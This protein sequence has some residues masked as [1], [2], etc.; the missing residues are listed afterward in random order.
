MT[1]APVHPRSRGEHI[2]G[3][4]RPSASAGSSPLARG[5]LPAGSAHPRRHRFIP[6]R[7]GNTSSAST[8]ATRRPV[9]PRSRGEH[10]YPS[11]VR[12]TFA[13]SSPLARGTRAARRLGMTR[14]RFIPARAGNTH[15]ARS[16]SQTSPVHPR[17]RGEHVAGEERRGLQI[18]F[19]PA[20]A[21][22]TCTATASVPGIAVHPRSRGEHPPIGSTARDVAG[23]SP[24]ARGTRGRTGCD[25]DDG[26]FIPARAGEHSASRH[27][28]P[29]PA[30]SSPLARGTPKLERAVQDELRFIPARAGNTKDGWVLCA[31]RPVH[32]RSRGEHTMPWKS[33]ARAA[34]S[35]PLARGTRRSAG[36][37]RTR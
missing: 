25:A 20:R 36:T 7:A 35:S 27:K 17:S 12:G 29:H 21:G 23:S 22:N 11:G 3:H 6:A 13:G 32:P 37:M 8:P 24:L 9:H 19:I 14:L 10:A 34:G 16:P 18:R 4:S 15:A 2:S 31:A 26:R 30:G 28:S 33:I 5:T 1:R